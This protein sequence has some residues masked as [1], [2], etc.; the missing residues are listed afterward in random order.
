MTTANVILG[1]AVVLA[2]ASDLVLEDYYL[3]KIP[4][5]QWL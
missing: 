3:V 5:A 4:I 1:I 2:L